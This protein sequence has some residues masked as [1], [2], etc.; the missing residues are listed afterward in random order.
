[1]EERWRDFAVLQRG[2]KMERA[3]VGGREGVG[4]D[5]R[6]EERKER[7][8]GRQARQRQPT[9]LSLSHTHTILTDISYVNVKEGIFSSLTEH[10]NAVQCS[11]KPPDALCSGFKE[12]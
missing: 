3:E 7:E 9:V 11:K 6:S 10:S 4:K 5:V 2:E 1:M 12:E 8:D